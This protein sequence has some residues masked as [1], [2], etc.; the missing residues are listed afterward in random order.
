MELSRIRHLLGCL[1][2]QHGS[3]QCVGAAKRECK[4]GPLAASLPALRLA[5]EGDGQAEITS[6][7]VSPTDNM[8]PL[9]L[10]REGQS[11]GD[12]RMTVKQKG[13]D[14]IRIG[15]VLVQLCQFAKG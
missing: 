7:L 12:R 8:R 3:R 2:Q 10:I 1:Q 4:R 6:L 5:K 15:I 11:F 14:P 13:L 9:S